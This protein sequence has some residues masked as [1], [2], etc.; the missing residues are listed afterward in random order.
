[1]LN[2]V[3]LLTM[4][5]G[6]ASAVAASNASQLQP[7]RGS[8]VL[9]RYESRGFVFLGEPV[10]VEVTVD[11]HREHKIQADLGFDWTENFVVNVVDP[12]G[13]LHT[14]TL[15]KSCGP[16]CVGRRGRVVVS[17]LQSFSHQLVLDRWFRFDQ[18]GIYLL[19]L[20]LKSNIASDTGL[21]IEVAIV[22][23]VAVEVPRS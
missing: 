18:A 15:L 20:R 23:R 2:N 5:F 1:M 6:A 12:S 8:S 13:T 4:L 11:N 3:A 7:T 22:G 14:A 10:V 19:E 16:N 17:P 21:P 9:V